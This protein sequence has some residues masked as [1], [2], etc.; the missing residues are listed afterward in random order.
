MA[1]EI[2]I[3]TRG[4]VEKHWVYYTDKPEDRTLV[5][6]I[7]KNKKIV[8]FY[9]IY[10]E[11]A[12]EIIFEGFDAIPEIFIKNQLK[13]KSK[14]LKLL[15]KKFRNKNIKK[16]IVA[17]D[18]ENKIRKYGNDYSITLNYD[19]LVN[20]KQKLTGVFKESST[21]SNYVV[22]SFFHNIFPRHFDKPETTPKSKLNRVLK[23]LDEDIIEYLDHS[24]INKILNFV[25]KLLKTRHKNW[26]YKRELFKTT[27]I[28]VD[29]IAISEIISEFE[30][31]ISQSSSENEWA[32]FLEKNLFLID[33]KYVTVIPQLNVVL[34]SERRVDFG[35]IDSQG[36][37]DIFEIKKPSTRLLAHSQH[38]GNYYWN[39]EAIKAVVQAE[40]YFE[41]AVNKA[42]SLAADIQRE[43]NIN[44]KVKRP[45][46]FV[47][48]G[49]S[50]QLINRKMKDDF[51][52]LRGSL[53]NVEIILYDELLERLRNQKNK[54]YIE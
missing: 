6:K 47:I 1:R 9:P 12:D 4:N 17:K 7:D 21:D 38:R 27:K 41:N 28:K 20:L 19:S 33:S 16:F 18:K 24:D 30:N 32:D 31:K 54:I 22:D 40:K 52:I 11:F 44:V 48:M 8:S 13:M 45:R 39:T 35:L 14:L 2:E 34:A 36:Y 29:E 26:T 15:N 51:R 5:F 46:A 23:N 42:D 25:E 43:R 50:N 3:K 10:E 49:H 53:K 37:L